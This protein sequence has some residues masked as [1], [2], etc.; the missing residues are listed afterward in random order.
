MRDQ[1]YL[2]IRFADDVSRLETGKCG[3]IGRGQY[4]G[5]VLF[6]PEGFGALDSAGVEGF[7]EGHVYRNLD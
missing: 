4:L 1:K 5:T 6:Q 2:P 3:G 7:R